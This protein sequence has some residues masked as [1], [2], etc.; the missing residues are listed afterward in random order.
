MLFKWHYNESPG[1]GRPDLLKLG[2]V[3]IGE[4]YQARPDCWRAVCLLP[5]S[6]DWGK[7]YIDEFTGKGFATNALEICCANWLS[8]AGVWTLLHEPDTLAA[9]VSEQ[10]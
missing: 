9:N 7:N 6:S 3:T 5:D 4:V 1:F 2:N 8:K 10:G